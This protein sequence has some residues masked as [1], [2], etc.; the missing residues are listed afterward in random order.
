MKKK[1]KKKKSQKKKMRI[2]E[3]RVDTAA[4]VC[5]KGLSHMHMLVDAM[6]KKRGRKTVL[7][8]V[9][10]MKSGVDVRYY[11]CLWRNQRDRLC[12]SGQLPHTAPFI[13]P[14]TVLSRP[15][16]DVGITD[17]VMPSYASDQLLH[18]L[19]WG[20]DISK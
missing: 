20:V 18:T 13:Y 16:C 2:S 7:Y 6:L 14:S 12:V 11:H 4:A 19:Q 9:D 1:K 8:R 15:C 3:S 10:T 17:T 5:G